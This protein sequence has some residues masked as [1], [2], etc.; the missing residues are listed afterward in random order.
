MDKVLYEEMYRMERSHWWFSAKRGIV[1]SLLAEF[2]QPDRLGRRLR[3]ADL[4]CGCG[5]MLSDLAA[6]GYDAVGVDASDLALEFCRARSVSAVPGRLPGPVD[7]PDA[8]LDAMLML[9]VLEHIDDDGAAFASAVELIRPGGI[10][11]CTVPAYRWLWTARDEF[12]HHRRRYSR[13]LFTD[14]LRSAGDVEIVLISFMN[15]FLFPLALAVRLSARLLTR[16]KKPR[17]L[18][19]PRFGVNRLLQAVFGAERHLLIRRICMPFGLSL[20]AV[21]RRL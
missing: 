6:A 1:L 2:L 7:L 10:A 20:I 3:V 14:L 8:S 18:S 17:D 19:I 4:G 9:D 5:M 15:T 21:V 13:R 12:H 16:A 11:I